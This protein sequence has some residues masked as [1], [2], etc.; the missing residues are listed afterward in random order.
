MVPQNKLKEN[1]YHLKSQMK[2]VVLYSNF[3]MHH[4]DNILKLVEIRE[5]YRFKVFSPLNLSY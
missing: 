2:K 1:V 4:F 3:N 5:M